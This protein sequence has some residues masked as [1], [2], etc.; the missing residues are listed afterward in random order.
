MSPNVEYAGTIPLDSPGVGGKVVEV[1]DQTRFYV[2]GLKGITIYDVSDPA[3]PLP[4]GHLPF[5]HAQNEDV[6]VAQ[7]GG[8]S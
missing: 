2:T 4:L 6:E 3:V 7:T 8:E 5:P 1:G